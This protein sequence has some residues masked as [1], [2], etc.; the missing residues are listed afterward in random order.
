[1]AGAIIRGPA[2]I[3]AG[4]TVKMGAK[5]YGATTIGPV[6]K[7][8]GEVQN[9]IFHSYSNKAHDGFAG[10]SLF[11]QWCNIGAN[12]NTSNLKNNYN[13]VSVTDWES[14]RVW[15]TGTRFLGTMMGDHSKTGINTMLNTGTVIGVGC[16]IFGDG[17]APKHIPSFSWVNGSVIEEYRFD[18][19][20]ETMKIV[21]SR[22][23]VE[24]SD[25]YLSLMETIHT[26]R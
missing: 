19:S 8:A 11:G 10:N 2:A 14:G 22:R 3:C 13:P 15:D 25:S 7:V 16:N 1:M 9:V 21:M 17:F 6:C 5:I 4:S 20:A 18:K 24:L 26:G 23:N 12:T